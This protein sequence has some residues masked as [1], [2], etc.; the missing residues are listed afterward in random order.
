MII[1]TTVR[2]EE[3]IEIPSIPNFFK[4]GKEMV[5]ISEIPKEDLEKIA[6]AWKAN[7]IEKAQKL[8]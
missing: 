8:S 3:Q 1:S 2:R 7:L 6:E 4:K 5:P